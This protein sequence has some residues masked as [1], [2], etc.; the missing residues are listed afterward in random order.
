MSATKLSDMQAR[1]TVKMSE[2]DELCKKL[3]GDNTT[4]ADIDAVKAKNVEVEELTKSIATEKEV[5]DIR[6]KQAERAELA[7]TVNPADRPGMGG[8][9]DGLAT[10][11][12]NFEMPVT[13][14]GRS[15]KNLMPVCKSRDEA[16]H[17]AFALTKFVL[18]ACGKN[19]YQKAN[20]EAWC[21]KNGIY[22]KAQ[23][24]NINQ[25]GG[26][27]VPE[28]L[29]NFIISLMETAGVTRRAGSV[30]AYFLTDNQAINASTKLFDMISLTAKKLAAFIFYS[31]EIAEDAM[32]DIG[33]DLAKE[34][35]WQFAFKEDMCGILGDGTS[36]YGTIIGLE[37][38]IIKAQGA[39]TTTSNAGIHVGAAG[40]GAAFTGFVLDDFIAT[41]GLPPAYASNRQD[42]ASWIVSKQFYY[43]GMLA[44]L[45]AGGGNTILSLAAGSE[46]KP[47]FLG[48][49]VYFS[50]VMPTKAAN[51]TICALYGDYSLAAEFGDRRS[52]TIATSDQIGFQADQLAIRGIERFDINV[53]DVGGSDP[54]TLAQ[55]PTY[56][57]TGATKYA[58]PVVALQSNTS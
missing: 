19:T 25:D 41:M 46:G 49:P 16:Q 9:S 24:E 32:I 27:L 3:E 42:G 39:V 45:A 15:C 7:K 33:D 31:N 56:D 35:A 40:S 2:L 38:S 34:I 20:A 12:L 37:Q 54:S 22:T 28:V 53:H 57:Q 23:A 29:A 6:I 14:S 44:A 11:S 4:P 13:M 10:M 58:G 51:S 55:N 26:F 21:I 47:Q 52:L 36:T 43:T 8:G 18:A 48:A 1:M 5:E 17:V 30:T 50:P